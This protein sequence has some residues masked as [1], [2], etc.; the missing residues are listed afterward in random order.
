MNIVRRCKKEEDDEQIQIKMKKMKMKK[1][2][3]RRIRRSRNI[4][5]FN[6]FRRR[7]RGRRII[8]S[9]DSGEEEDGQTSELFNALTSS[10]FLVYSPDLA[11][12]SMQCYSA[13][14]SAS[15]RSALSERLLV[16]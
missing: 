14:Y 10:R 12:P 8:V 11:S 7:T 9:T 15:R 6:R 4:P 2:I 5:L 13:S 1:K 3:R 16:C